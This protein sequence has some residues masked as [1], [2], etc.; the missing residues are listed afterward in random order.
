MF[1]GQAQ[2]LACRGAGREKKQQNGLNIESHEAYELSLAHRVRNHDGLHT[3]PNSV[4]NAIQQPLNHI[5]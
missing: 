5:S 2:S 3:E 4:Q 1:L